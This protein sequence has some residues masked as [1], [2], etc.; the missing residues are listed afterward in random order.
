MLTLGRT[1]PT[2]GDGK[3]LLARS[4]VGWFFRLPSPAYDAGSVVPPICHL[5][6]LAAPASPAARHGDVQSDNRHATTRDW[7]AGVETVVRWPRYGGPAGGCPVGQPDLPLHL[8]R[9]SNRHRS[10]GALRRRQ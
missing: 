10:T 3:G 6:L 2:G 4:I 7:R 5:A 9:G 8:Q 1:A